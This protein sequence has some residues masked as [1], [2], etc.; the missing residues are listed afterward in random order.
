MAAQ[1]NVPKGKLIINFM[2]DSPAEKAGIRVNDVIIKCNGTDIVEEDVLAEIIK[3]CSVGDKVT[4]TVLRNGQE[5]SFE[6]T[7]GD[8]NRMVVLD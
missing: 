8:M 2:N 4:L 7:I 1:M 3:N 6:V 5:L